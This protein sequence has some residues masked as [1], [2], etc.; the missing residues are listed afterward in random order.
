MRNPPNG[1]IDQ[2]HDQRHFS[3]E[4]IKLAGTPHIH[5]QPST[6]INQAQNGNERPYQ[7]P[8]DERQHSQ[9]RDG[10]SSASSDSANKNNAGAYFSAPH[11]S[12]EGDDGSAHGLGKPGS[13]GKAKS[14]LNWKKGPPSCSECIRLKLKVSTQL[15]AAGAQWR[16]GGPN[17]T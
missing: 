12:A 9:Q 8:S 13:S 5:P 10:T 7:P 17:L 6:I 15:Q 3:A 2:T 16:I 14:K 4:Q 1:E 11:H